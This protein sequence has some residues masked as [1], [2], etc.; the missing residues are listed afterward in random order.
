M[1]P[2]AQ[3]PADRQGQRESQDPRPRV[4]AKL[5]ELNTVRHPHSAVDRSLLDLRFDKQRF[6]VTGDIALRATH[7][8]PTRCC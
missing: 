8:P 4:N 1:E 7:A 3:A 6:A 2:D 5:D